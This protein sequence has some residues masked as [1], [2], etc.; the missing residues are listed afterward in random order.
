M[1]SS[2]NFRTVFSKSQNANPL[3]AEP[4]THFSAKWPFKVIKGHLFPCQWRAL[5]GYIVQHN[6]CGLEYEGSE[7]IA[8]ERSENRHFRRPYSHLTSSLQPTPSNKH[9][10]LILLETRIPALH[11]CRW[12]FVDVQIFEQLCPKSRNANPLVAEPK[13]NFNA[14]WVFKVIQCHLFRC[15]WRTTMGLHCVI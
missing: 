14:K 9:M 15:H 1:R 7:D 13:T 6:N 5:R 10:N 11:F 4:E 2:A 3:D 8:S 12:Q